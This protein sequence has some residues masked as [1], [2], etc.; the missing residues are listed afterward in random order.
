MGDLGTTSIF[1]SARPSVNLD[2]QTNDG[3][4]DGLLT[5]LAEET[6]AGLFRCE[7]SFGNWGTAN[8][9]VGFLY[10]DRQVLDFGKT[11][12][13]RI[14][15]GETES[16]IFK[17]QI[18]GLEAH[19]PKTRP[20]EIVVLAEDRFQ[21][22]RM[23]RRSRSF[24]NVT[25]SD[26]IQQVASEHGLRADIDIDGPTYQVLAQVNQSD[27]AFLRDRALL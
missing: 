6:T 19:Y 14:G 20:P 21:D 12:A 18:T 9:G 26:V 11:L 10:L 2:D 15:E 24:E 16:Q 8:G 23:T 3:L 25:D 1:Y 4:T 27:L 5:M 17:G 22:L 7:A 13:I